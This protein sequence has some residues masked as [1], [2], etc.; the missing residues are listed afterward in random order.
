MLTL[1]FHPNSVKI[2]ISRKSKDN[3]GKSYQAEPLGTDQ[4]K[5]DQCTLLVSRWW[6]D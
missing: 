2:Y 4:L 5:A 6:H 1:L 3:M